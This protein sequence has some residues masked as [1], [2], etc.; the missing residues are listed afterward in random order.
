MKSHVYIISNEFYQITMIDTPGLLDTRGINEDIKNIE[1]ILS[2]IVNLGAIHA[3]CLVHKSTDS[4]MD[5]SFK[6]Y[7]EEFR[8]ILPE[9]ALK[10]LFVCLTNVVNPKKNDGLISLKQ[11]NLPLDNVLFFE[12]DCLLPFSAVDDEDYHKMSQMFWQTNEKNYQKLIIHCESLDPIPT[13]IFL[14]I[15]IYKTIFFKL[16]FVSPLQAFEESKTQIQLA[17]N[18]IKTTML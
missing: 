2:T 14:P 12:N 3:I 16:D 13:Q 18:E 15:V 11:M 6:Y 4:R 10:N 1:N 7:T 5:A 9:R 8:S 17:I